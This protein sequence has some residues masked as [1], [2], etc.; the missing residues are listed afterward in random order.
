MNRLVAVFILGLT[1]VS[2]GQISGRVTLSN[3]TL[4]LAQ[5]PESLPPMGW[6]SWYGLTC[7]G[8]EPCSGAGIGD[9]VVTETNIKVQADAL[10]SS[11]LAAV[12]YTLVSIDDTWSSR[13]GSGNLQG[14]PANFPSGMAA[15][16]TYI[17]GKGLL[18]G[19]YGA[20]G[21]LSCAGLG[22]PTQWG[23]EL[24]DAATVAAW[25]AD[26]WKEDWCTDAGTLWGPNTP[27]FSTPTA[28]VAQAY[29]TMGNAL[30]ASGRSI[31]LL[32]SYIPSDAPSFFQ[33]VGGSMVRI[34]TDNGQTC[35]CLKAQNSLAY[36]IPYQNRGHW[37][38]PDMLMGG[39]VENNG[40]STVSDVEAKAQFNWYAIIAAPLIIGKQINLLN[41]TLL[42]TYGNSE[43][44]AIDQDALGKMGTLVSSTTCGSTVCQVWTRRLAN[45]D[46]AIA[47]INYD[48][49]ASH[50]VTVNWSM[51]GQ[52][53]TWNIRDLWAH[54]SAGSSSTGYSVSLPAWGSTMVKITQ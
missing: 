26:F 3:A 1:A 33:Q 50:S 42:T 34:G 40:G 24:A 54:A 44:I 52:S 4:S 18:F 20:A 32:V 13:D 5:Y 9:T 28:S 30:T 8:N 21:T 41:S 46:Y 16:G 11:G 27:L 2:S 53:G 51:F 38:D 19:L 31:P 23:H 43:V 12:G 39:M 15:L 22:Y 37:L 45:G 10:V 48:P 49:S 36:A 7:G 35:W 25:G 17:H 14:V 6:N 29:R 47:L